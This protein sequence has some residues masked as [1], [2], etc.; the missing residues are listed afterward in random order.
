MADA[1]ASGASVR[2]GVGVQIPPRA[3]TVLSQD[4]ESSNPQGRGFLCFA[5]ALVRG[6][7]AKDPLL[8]L[9]VSDMDMSWIDCPLHQDEVDGVPVVWR[10]G[11]PPLQA[12]LQFR[13]GI[14]DETFVTSGITHAVE[15]LA[16]RAVGRWPQEVNAGVGNL[17]TDFSTSG[18]PELV[19]DFL[20]A[21]C[22]ALSALPVDNLAL[23]LGVLETEAERGGGSPA[24]SLLALRLGARGPGLSGF[25]EPAL[26]TITAA[27]VSEWVARWFVRGNAVLALSGPPP[28]GLR[29]SLPDG[30]R[31][32]PPQVNP[33]P[34]PGRVWD[35]LYD[36]VALGLLADLPDER[37]Q[38]AFWSGVRIAGDRVERILRHERGLAYEVEG[39]ITMIGRRVA[40]GVVTADSHDRHA[41]EV[42]TVL[43][44][45]LDSLATTGP[46]SEELAFDLAQLREGLTDPRGVW[47]ST[48]TRA[49]DLLIGAEG[50]AE[51]DRMRLIQSMDGTEVRD[52][53]AA[54]SGNAMLLVPDDIEVDRPGWQRASASTS[55]PL[56][57]QVLRRRFRSWAPRGA[58]LVY[59]PDEGVTLLTDQPGGNVTAR[60]DD[61][62][63]VGVHKEGHLLVQTGDGEAVPLRAQDWR[64]GGAAIAALRTQVPE[65]LFFQGPDDD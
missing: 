28:E 51:V 38:E 22:R 39:W 23:E 16:M 44:D 9:G 57:G 15:H 4:L 8:L 35:D 31:Q 5:G 18:R 32:P 6:P 34:L 60:W 56:K 54:V 10:E 37:L 55:P 17:L 36:G 26:R 2:K 65:R 41:A 48:D 29:L 3:P 59:S 43:V 45:T 50:P 63:G 46:T 58:R 12:S 19:A 64:G 61:I 62:V 47:A 7:H 49:S 52:A 14:A 11:P 1:L 24:D 30:P 13:V 25:D 53:L 40:H 33:R 27:E 20:G 42:V 21:I